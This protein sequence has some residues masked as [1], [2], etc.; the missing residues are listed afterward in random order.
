MISVKND[1]YG[2]DVGDEVLMK[3]SEVFLKY[4]NDGYKA[5]A[6]R[7]GGEEFLFAFTDTSEM[8]THDYMENLIQK[9]RLMSIVYG[10]EYLRVTMTFGVNMLKTTQSLDACITM[11]D[12]KLY[13]GKQTGRTCF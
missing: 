2:H 10:G 1:K 7:W 13:Y 5:S 3:V 9:I 12:K 6:T 8:K 4:A 11:A